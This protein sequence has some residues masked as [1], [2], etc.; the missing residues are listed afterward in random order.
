MPQIILATKKVALAM[1]WTV[2]WQEGRP[3]IGLFQLCG[4]GD[5]D[6]I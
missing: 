3:E 1:A 2:A 4:G 5:F 6:F